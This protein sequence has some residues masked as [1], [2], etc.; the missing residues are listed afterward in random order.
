MRPGDFYFFLV[1][2]PA[3]LGAFLAQHKL[4]AAIAVA[5]TLTLLGATIRVLHAFL[6][7]VK[8]AGGYTAWQKERYAA[9]PERETARDTE[10]RRREGRKMVKLE[11]REQRREFRR[12]TSP[13]GQLSLFR[14][15]P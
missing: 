5:V 15:R 8:R 3:G 11:G 12:R 2:P 9:V 10:L 14:Y 4:A 6:M 13:W 7:D 1:P